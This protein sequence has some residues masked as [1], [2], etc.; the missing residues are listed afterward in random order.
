MTVVEAGLSCVSGSFFVNVGVTCA[1]CFSC[2]AL[3]ATL[4]AETAVVPF[5]LLRD[6]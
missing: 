5:R 2:E 1:D 4:Q 3:S 6:F